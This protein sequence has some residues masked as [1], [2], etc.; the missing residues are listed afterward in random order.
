MPN[1]KSTAKH[2]PY[3]RLGVSHIRAGTVYAADRFNDEQLKKL[4]EDPHLVVAET[5]EAP[6]AR[7]LV[8]SGQSPRAAAF[9]AFCQGV[10]ARAIAVAVDA[11][12]DWEGLG[13]TDRQS[14][15]DAVYAEFV[16]QAQ[17]AKERRDPVPTTAEQGAA[18]TTAK[19]AAAKSTAKKA[20]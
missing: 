4:R 20:K 11:G 2:E 10:E 13:E 14:R 17:E 19:P 9:M 18:A 6:T 7:V 15:I 1:I 5:D 16:E 8:D 3:R 12:L